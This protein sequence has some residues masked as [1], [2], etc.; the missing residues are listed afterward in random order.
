M[1]ARAAGDAAMGA[2]M[3]TQ[4]GGSDTDESDARRK[5]L[6]SAG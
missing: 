2:L 3:I 6:Y 1:G 4:A 5:S